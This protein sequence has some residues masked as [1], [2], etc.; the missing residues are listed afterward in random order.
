MKTA[1][2]LVLALGIGFAFGRLI[3]GR[4]GRPADDQS[5]RVTRDVEG[6][7]TATRDEVA[8]RTQPN[9][10]PRRL[11]AVTDDSWL[12]HVLLDP[13]HHASDAA[14]ITRAILER[15]EAI[16]A[17]HACTPLFPE[18]ESKVRLRTQIAI[19]STQIDIGP[20][21]SVH[22]ADGIVLSEEARDCL[23]RAFGSSVVSKPS[24]PA[25]VHPY[26]G[27]FDFSISVIGDEGE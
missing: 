18:T 20:V 25:F 19:S 16:E 11:A 4:F 8:P 7:S 1:T 13:E 3:P 14:R 9:E 17:L 12:A 23:L 5:R 22:V 21:E 24:Y 2:T 26:Q 6:R 27:P 10:Q 15:R